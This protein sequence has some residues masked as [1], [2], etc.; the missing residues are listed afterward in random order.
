MCDECANGGN[1]SAFLPRR[2]TLPSIDELEG[3][4]TS[5][6]RVTWVAKSYF[7]V[8]PRFLRILLLYFLTTFIIYSQ[9]IVDN[10]RLIGLG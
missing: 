9:T 5:T 2:C 1:Y 8:S 7:E 3:L 4:A 6:L 10:S